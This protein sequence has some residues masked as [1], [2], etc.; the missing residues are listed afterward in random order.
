M[1]GSRLQAGPSPHPFWMAAL[2]SRLLCTHV[3]SRLKRK[4]KAAVAKH[5]R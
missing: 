3:M 2:G 5:M 4:K 1:G